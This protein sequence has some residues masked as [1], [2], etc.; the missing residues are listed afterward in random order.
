MTANSKT[1]IATKGL[2][3]LELRIAVADAYDAGLLVGQ[4][5]AEEIGQRVG[6]ASPLGAGHACKSLAF[7][8]QPQTKVRGEG[9][10]KAPM[11]TTPAQWTPP[12]SWPPLFVMAR[13]LHRAGLSVSAVSNICRMAINIET[14]IQE[15]KTN[16]EADGMDLGKRG[17][18]S[19][20]IRT[21]LV[22]HLAKED[23]FILKRAVTDAMG[24]SPNMPETAVLSIIKQYMTGAGRKDSRQ[25]ELEKTHIPKLDLTMVLG[26][27]PTI[28]KEELLNHLR[29]LVRSGG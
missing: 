5:S 16:V 29:G 3:G 4:H 6:A 11:I 10:R 17:A 15:A 7:S 8:F 19:K 14:I 25:D 23:R 27:R 2:T 18:L 24:E 13:N 26:V 28:D 9:G 21:V 1:H 22:K 12:A 20:A